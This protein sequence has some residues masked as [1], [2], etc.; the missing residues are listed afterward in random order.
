MPDLE[1][2][3]QPLVG[4]PEEG[5]DEVQIEVVD[6]AP[7]AKDGESD[8]DEI[9]SYS[10]R[11]QKRIKRLTYEFHEERRQK[12][13]LEREHAETL[14]Y[15]QTVHAQ[16]EVLRKGT[17]AAQHVIKKTATDK[18]ESDLVKTRRDFKEA[19]EAGDT[20]KMTSAQEQLAVLATEKRSLAAYDPD[21]HQM[22]PAAP[23]PPKPEPVVSA[24]ASNWAAE[25]KWF[26]KDEEMTGYAMGVHQRLFNSGV[27]TNS[28]EYY[29]AIDSAVSK[30]FADK[31]GQQ[32]PQQQMQLVRKNA[33]VAPS[34]RVSGASRKVTLTATQVDLARKLGI[35]PQQYAKQVMEMETA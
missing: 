31:F 19:Y 26:G 9:G 10:D 7:P 4:T 20:D 32:K 30:R 12:E 34:T 18:T 8:E 5:A 33:V 25:N 11:V 16:N 22:V 29:E 17:L 2:D 21:A 24:K 13:R 35:T 3:D 1:L 15:A 6:D 14:R 27:D 23:P 28:E